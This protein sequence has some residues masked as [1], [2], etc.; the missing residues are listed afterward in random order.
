MLL[1]RFAQADDLLQPE[2]YW[3]EA[4]NGANWALFVLRGASSLGVLQSRDDTS[5][6]SWGSASASPGDLVV[7][8]FTPNDSAASCSELD[9]GTHVTEFGHFK[10][11]FLPIDATGRSP[12]V[13]VDCFMNGPGQ[14]DQLRVFA[15]P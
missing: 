7:D 1:T 13:S 6:L 5:P 2:R 11:A 14:A 9:G 3:F 15:A 10:V 4:P 12:P 8:A